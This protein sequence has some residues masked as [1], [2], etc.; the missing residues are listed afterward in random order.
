M[1]H[2]VRIVSVRE[3]LRYAERAIAYFQEAWADE[4][5]RMVYDDCI[6][7]AVGAPSSLPQWY[8][9]MDGDRTAGCAGLATNDFCS[10][11]D[12]WPWLVALYVGE[13]YRGRNY[14]HLLIGRAMRDARA[15]GFG[16]FYLCTDHTAYYERFGFVHI[17]KCYHP[18]G[19][20]SRLYEIGL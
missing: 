13:E 17:G 2:T 11:M 4:A 3:E 19:A 1:E 6:R 7:H 5:G 8:L 9:L 12:L 15:A 14:G 20:S 16:K 18:W 10:R